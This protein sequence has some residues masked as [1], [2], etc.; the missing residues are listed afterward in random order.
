MNNADNYIEEQAEEAAED[1]YG[2]VT[3]AM[4]EVLLADENRGFYEY[5]RDRGHKK[6]CLQAKKCERFY[7][8][9]GEQW[10]EADKIALGQR[11][12]TECNEIMP[13]VN[14]ALAYQINNRMDVTL[15]P[16]GE[17][18]EEEAEQ[19]T[20]VFK[21]I[22]DNCQYKWR[23]TEVTGDGLIQQRG[24]FDLRVQFDDNMQGEVELSVLD[25]MDVIPDP[26][27]KAYDPD[28][29]AWVIITRWYTLDQIE[30]IFGKDKRAPIENYIASADDRDWGD[31]FSEEERAKFGDESNSGSHDY[32]ITTKGIKRARVI[33]RQYW[34]YE[35]TKVVISPEGD[36][37]PQDSIPPGEIA[38]MVEQGYLANITKMVRRVKWLV[39]SE[40]TVLFHDYSPFEHFTV[41]PYLSLIH[42]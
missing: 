11:P 36:V 1:E 24:F 42:I 10:S 3:S 14:I 13:A 31:D 16:R 5:G 37:I 17:S 8:G 34:V 35:L 9:G 28:E 20:K 32:Y 33:D 22:M 12:A 29:W 21:Q 23:E 19:M 6:Y 38:K 18:D 39:T 4:N 25:P 2:S 7:L 40:R 26:D 15:L 41:V 30:Q 27:A